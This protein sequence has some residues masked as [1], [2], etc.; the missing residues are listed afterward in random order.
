MVG[1]VGDGSFVLGN[2]LAAIQMIQAY[3]RPHLTVVYTNDGWRAVSDTITDQYN[4]IAFDPTAFTRFDPGID[5]AAL[6]EGCNC[7]G[8]RVSAPT[9]LEGSLKR[10][11]AAVEDGPATKSSAEWAT[12]AQVVLNGG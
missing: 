10:A 5:Y 8:E 7:H 1:V 4:E 9:E 3:D 2:P 11:L 6:A 12:L